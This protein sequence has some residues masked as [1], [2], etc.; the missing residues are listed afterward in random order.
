M[1]GLAQQELQYC[2]RDE[3][4]GTCHLWETAATAE[5]NLAEWESS[6]TYVRQN[7]PVYSC[8][9]I[10]ILALGLWAMRSGQRVYSS[11]GQKGIT[12]L[13]SAGYKKLSNGSRV[14]I[15]HLCVYVSTFLAVSCDPVLTVHRSR[16]NLRVARAARTCR[17]PM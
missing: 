10:I 14:C 2:P 3:P 17:G 13:C 9:F 5:G 12:M 16:C 1:R 15:M 7:S 6:R 4:S 8:S 11:Q